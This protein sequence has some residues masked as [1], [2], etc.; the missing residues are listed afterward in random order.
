MPLGDSITYGVGSSTNAGYR[1]P[2]QSLLRMISP[3][4]SLNMVGTQ[5]DGPSYIDRDHEGYP[6]ARI[7]SIARAASCSVAKSR[8]NVVTLHAGTNDMRDEYVSDLATAPDRLGVLIDQIL[9]SSPNATVLVATLVP[10]TKEN[11]QPRIDAYNAQVRTLVEQRRSHGWHVRLVEMT[12][13]TTADL[14]QPAH[15]SDK[16]YLKMALAWIGGI[17]EANADGWLEPPADPTA[18]AEC[19]TEDTQQDTDAGLGWRS[20]GVI[21]PGMTTPEGHTDLVELNSDDRADYVRIA[22]DGS[23]R[24]AL[25]TQ[26]EPGKPNWVDQG[27]ISPGRG[28]GPEAVRFADINGDGRDDYL[29]VGEAGSVRAWRNNGPGAADGPYHWTDLGVIAPGVS[30]ITRDHLRFADVNGDGRDDYLRVSDTAA[31]H[32]YFNTQTVTG[33]IH[34]E[35]HLNWAP[36]V[37]YGTLD[38]LRLSDVNGDR[39][40]DYLMV[41]SD[42]RVH[43]YIN[44]GGAGAGGFTPYLNYVTPIDMPGSK[45]TFRDISGDGRADYVG[46][47]T[48]GSVVAWLNIGGNV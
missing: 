1:L 28:H 35:E 42:A 36:G 24:A 25:N 37:S 15:P 2:L 34:W 3:T 5:H 18:G 23:V 4:A 21:A 14:A 9:N 38:K 46:I 7:S 6:G 43:A 19:S 41:G 45:M 8:P 32:A 31:I 11:L 12:S 48:G 40:A 20:L 13:V 44:N 29:V 27:I 26:G 22:A 30:G 10:A 16:G 47:Y 17:L 33:S 39:K